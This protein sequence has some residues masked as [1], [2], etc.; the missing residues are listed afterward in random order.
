MTIRGTNGKEFGCHRCNAVYAFEPKYV[1]EYLGSLYCKNCFFMKVRGYIIND[2]YE[3]SSPHRVFEFLRDTFD[4]KMIPHD[5][6]DGWYTFYLK[7]YAIVHSFQMDIRMKFKE[8]KDNILNEINY[9]NTMTVDDVKGVTLR[10]WNEL[11]RREEEGKRKAPSHRGV[12]I[13]CIF[14]V[15]II[16]MLMSRI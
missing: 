4:M 7:H 11:V 14:L 10:T 9:M 16:I 2:T 1:H 6:Y 13:G 8:L 15:C 5:T 12:I 3:S